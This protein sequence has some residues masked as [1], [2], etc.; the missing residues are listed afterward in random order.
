[1]R[2]GDAN[3]TRGREVAAVDWPQCVIG[4]T[5][6]ILVT[7]NH[8]KTCLSSHNL[9]MYGKGINHYTLWSADNS[10]YDNLT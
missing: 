6:Q 8:A 2:F 5:G 7:E 4:W 9:W 3:V 1:M 10:Y